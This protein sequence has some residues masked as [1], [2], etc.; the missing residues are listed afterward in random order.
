MARPRYHILAAALLAVPAY[1]TRGAAAVVGLFASGVL[2]DADHLADYA[3]TRWRGQR[4]HYLAPLHGWELAAAAAALAALLPAPGPYDRAP[5]RIIRRDGRARRRWLPA[6]V[7]GLAVGWWIHLIQDVLT[8]RPQHA[9]V[10]SL[11]YR[12][13]HG[14]RREITGWGEHTRFHGW[15]NRPWYT[16]Y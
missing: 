13:W 16:W 11:A 9:G 6:L 1:R 14:F 3:W 10:Y 12:A 2:L 7:A 15:S 4:S 5:D 8:N